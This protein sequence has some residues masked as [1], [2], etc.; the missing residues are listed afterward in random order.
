M[1]YRRQNGYF[2]FEEDSFAKGAQSKFMIVHEV[3]LLLKVF[4]TIPPVKIKNINQYDLCYTIIK[5]LSEEGEK[6]IPDDSF[7]VFSPQNLHG[8]VNNT[9]FA[10]MRYNERFKKE[11]K[12]SQLIKKPNT[13]LLNKK[14]NQMKKDWRRYKTKGYRKKKRNS[15]NKPKEINRETEKKQNKTNRKRD[16]VR[17]QTEKNKELKEYER[18]EMRKTKMRMILTSFG[19]STKRYQIKNICQ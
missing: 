11:E 12:Q 7:Q 4:K 6:E 18:Y 5:I 9:R 3:I 15:E 19:Y 16:I 2:E 13:T 14:N 17:K 8:V 1:I 10:M